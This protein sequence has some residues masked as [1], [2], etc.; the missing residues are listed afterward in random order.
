MSTRFPYAIDDQYSLYTAKDNVYTFLTTG[1]SDATTPTSIDVV[2]TAD[3]PEQGI[4]TVHNKNFS[5]YEKFYYTGKT[6]T[7][8][9]GITRTKFI[10]FTPCDCNI[11]V[12]ILNTEDY[13][14]SV[15]DAVIEVEKLIH[16]DST[17][18]LLILTDV[19]GTTKYVDP[20]RGKWLSTSR[21]NYIYSRGSDNLLS[22]YLRF[23]DSIATSVSG[24]RS[25]RNLTVVGISIQCENNV[26]ANF[27][28]RKNNSIINLYSLALVG[29]NGDQ[30]NNLN[31]D[32]NLG[33]TLQI[34]MQV[35][36]GRV[37]KP[38]VVIE[39]AWRF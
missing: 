28:I 10:S 5:I 25:I 30:K 13:H 32:M 2:S 15:R 31:L 26:N 21:Q 16:G 1:I 20:T 11:Y 33:D 9:I 4:I 6:V 22:Q 35:N 24:P 19:D 18:G 14:N 17:S 8:F 3:F 23:G 7:S 37:N 38:I 34:Y 36:A 39:F 27:N 29:V 12:S